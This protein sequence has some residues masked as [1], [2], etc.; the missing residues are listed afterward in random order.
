MSDPRYEKALDVLQTIGGSEEG[1]RTLV[2]FFESQGALGSAVLRTGVGEIWAR[3][4]F[5]RRDRSVVVI[6]ALAAMGREMELRQH[7]GAGLNHGLTRDEIDEI[8]LQLAVYVGAPFALG[9]AAVAGRVFAE[10]DG[11]ETRRTPPSPAEL[12]DPEKRRAD[13]LDVLKTLLG[14]PD[15]DTALTEQQIIASQGDMGQLVMDY[16]F[17]DVWARPH[18]SRRDRSLVVISALAACNLKHEL[19]IH[20]GGA[21]NHGLT[22]AEVEEVMITIVLYGGFPRAIDGMILARKVFAARDEAG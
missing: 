13:G 1:A 18:L 8:M 3:T 20:I 11:T 16:A 2:D 4:E 14:N 22:R 19:E 21:L 7:I 17:G 15:L 10:R 9:G 12:K 6:S 5:S